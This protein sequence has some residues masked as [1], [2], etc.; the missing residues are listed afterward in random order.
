MFAAWLAVKQAEV[1]MCGSLPNLLA[2]PALNPLPPPGPLLLQ[3]TASQL[4]VTEK[5]LLFSCAGGAA[6]QP[7]PAAAAVAACV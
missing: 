2:S 5:K 6:A 7:R 3:S 1:L 4:W